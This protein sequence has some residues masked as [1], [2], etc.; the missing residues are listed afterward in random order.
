MCWIYAPF[1]IAGVSGYA[2]TWKISMITFYQYHA[3][4]AHHFPMIPS[5]RVS[6]VIRT[7][8]RASN[9]I[10]ITNQSERSRN[11]SSHKV[12]VFSDIQE[13]VG[14]FAFDLRRPV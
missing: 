12:P 7:V 3:S 13:V 14:G 8:A 1:I 9:S 5:L 11:V 10:A 6:G 4:N 2:V